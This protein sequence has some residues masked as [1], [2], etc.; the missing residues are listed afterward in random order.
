MIYDTI[1]YNIY[2]IYVWY[3]IWWYD[4]IGYDIYDMIRYDICMIYDIWHMIND[5]VWH[6][7]C[8]I[9]DMIRYGILYDMIYFIY[10]Y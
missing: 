3:M 5:M 1:W 6:D 10:I 8:M 2:D 4:V 7:I 9:Y